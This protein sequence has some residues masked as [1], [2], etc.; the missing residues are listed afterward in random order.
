MTQLLI[1]ILLLAF[2]HALIPNH[3]L[4]LVAIAKTENWEKAELMVVASLTA[5]AHV[6]G[7]VLLG[8]IL[9]LLGS[10][11]AHQFDTYVHLITPVLLIVLGLIYFFINM[12]HSNHSS[13]EYVRNSKKSKT[14]WILIFTGMMFLSPCLEVESLF[15]AAGPFGLNS[16]MI[17]AMVY[18]ATSIFAIVSLVLLGHKGIN[19]KIG[20]AHV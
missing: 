18:A 8:I 10:K 6:L 7:T 17:L 9:W 15:L 13:K 20:R 11:L 5:S 19:M 12:S 16:I 2:V 1:G 14:R 3:W 4:P